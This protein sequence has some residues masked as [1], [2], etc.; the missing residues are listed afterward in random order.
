MPNLT[1]EQFKELQ[2][3]M[4]EFVKGFTRYADKNGKDR[5]EVLQY[6]S[7][8]FSVMVSSGSYDN[9]IKE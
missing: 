4:G 2:N 9:Y 7:N 8:I 3:L 6:V 1:N 5:K